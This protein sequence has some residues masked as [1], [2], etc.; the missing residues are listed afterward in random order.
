MMGFGKDGKMSVMDTFLASGT[1]IPVVVVDSA[2]Q[3]A[4]IQ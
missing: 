4:G 3:I 2:T 1:P